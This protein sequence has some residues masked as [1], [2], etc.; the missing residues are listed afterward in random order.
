MLEVHNLLRRVR[1]ADSIRHFVETELLGSVPWIFSGDETRFGDWRTRVATAANLNATAIHLVGSA[2]TGYSLSPLKPGRAFRRV[3]ARDT[4]PSDIDI[5]IIDARLFLDVWDVIV[6]YDRR[7]QL[8]RILPRSGYQPA[9]DELVRVRQNVYW[10]TIAHTSAPPGTD[11]SRRFRSVFSATTRD[12]PF[13]G[14]PA[15]ARVYRR[16]D[17]LVAYHEQSVQQLVRTLESK[18]Y[19]NE[20][21][22][23]SNEP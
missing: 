18:E 19:R 6:G 4:K 13:L 21:F 10:G 22:G 11:V 20:V 15:K 9:D 2:S 3:G 8:R 16:R 14:H 1:S 5:A 7:H 23:N 17:D 12:R